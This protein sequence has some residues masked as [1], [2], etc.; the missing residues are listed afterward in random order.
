[1]NLLERTETAPSTESTPLNAPFVFYTE[2]R[3]VV[4]TGRKARNL[5]ELLSHLYQVSGSSVFYHTH[6]LYLIHH[7][8]K[9]RF[10]NEFANWVSHA[11]QEERLAER[12]AGIDLLAI[13]S[14]RE[15]R[16]AIISTIQEHMGSSGRRDCPAGDEFHFCEAKSFIM[17]TGMVA[18]SVPEF[19]EEISRVSN[20]C[21]HFHFFEARLRIERPT[22]DFSKWL[23]GLGEAKLADAID[24]LDPYSVTL[25]ELKEQIMQ[26]RK[27]Y[28]GQ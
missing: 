24:K 13:T 4:L 19:F 12:L 25:D 21:L 5:E 14:I 3:L 11:L 16:E 26:L 15:L 20:S 7:F 1:M 18:H 17:P 9:P 22:N 23:S 2:R 10:Y 27:H 28:R 8:E 6:Y